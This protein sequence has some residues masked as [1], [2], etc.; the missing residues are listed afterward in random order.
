MKYELVIFDLDG[1][2]L[3]TLQDLADST[4]HA[5]EYFGLPQR[6]IDEV[7]QFVGNGIHKLIERAVPAGSSTELTEQ[8][9][10]EFKSWYALHC[11]DS[12]GAY[13]GIMK[14]LHDLRQNHV[15]LAVVSNK[16]DF[17]VQTLCN[18]YFEGMLD[19]AVGERQG[20]Q[21]KPAPDSVNE[22]LRQLGVSRNHAVY[23][24][25]SDVDIETAE[26]AGMDCISVTWG[27][28]DETFLKE[29][30]AEILVDH[31][32]DILNIVCG[33]I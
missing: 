18:Q 31:P 27:F 4:N 20:I 1:T 32:S 25:D 2:L 21:K 14:L 30:R 15:R 28:R 5:L 29:H 6:T 17:G 12:T 22:V 23:V 3:D 33:E 13:D 11:N 24:G 26:N 16:A 19:A 8:V 9:F 7:R 10:E